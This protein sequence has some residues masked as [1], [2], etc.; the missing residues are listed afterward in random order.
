MHFSERLT[1]LDA[2]FL[3]LEDERTH[4]HVAALLVFEAGPLRRADGGLDIDRVRAL[5]A[6][7]L[8][9]VPRYRQKLARAPISDHP[10]WVED[11]N[12]NLDY[13]V[14]HT[15]LPPPADDRLLKRLA[16]RIMSQKLDREK[17][18]WEL[19]VVEGLADDRFAIITKAHHCMVD[20]I[21]GMAVI[22]TLLRP[23]PDDTIEE[24]SSWF[25]RPRPSR[26][27]MLVDE[28]AHRARAPFGLLRRAREAVENPVGTAQ[29]ALDAAWAVA[30]TLAGSLRPASDTPLNPDHIG[31]YRRFDWLRFDLDAV[32]EVKR[33][34]GG[35]VNDVVLATVAGGIGEFLKRRRLTLEDLDFRAM[36]P[37]NV[38]PSADHGKLGNR[39]AMLMA[40]LPVGEPDPLRRLERVIATTRELKHSR[41]IRGVE[42]MEEL[43]DWTTTGL[44]TQSTR[45]AAR[46]RAFNLVVTNI[47]GPQTQLYL[48]GAP[49]LAPYPMVP[50]YSNQALGIALF[51]YCG[52]LFWGFNSDW[53]RL[54]DLHDLVECFA[55][56]FEKLR[57]AASRTPKP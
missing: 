23:T 35:T 10:I 14:R 42:L 33:R 44:I 8:H 40:A 55:L 12:F 15:A 20:G 6:S 52:G 57:K 39:V 46:I 26:A 37:V 25:P 3:D 19:W 45:L 11:R 2:S 47:P 31:P 16:G 21:A 13:H 56:D 29:S 28:V 7:R 24:P 43:S 53:D 51:S 48:L 38:R 1:A 5:I 36:I 22:A 4:M 34:L 18:L 27:R 54:P 49:L 41:R 17:P 50:L 9:D 30:E 32:A